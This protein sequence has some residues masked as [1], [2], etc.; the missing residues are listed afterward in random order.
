MNT[1]PPK[2]RFGT[3]MFAARVGDGIHWARTQED[4][5]VEE[6][7]PRYHPDWARAVVEVPVLREV[8]TWNL[9]MVLRRR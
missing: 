5:V 3:S 9:M 6:L 2:N 1:S 4:L 7:A 8:A